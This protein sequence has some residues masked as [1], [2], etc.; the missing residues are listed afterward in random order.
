M[1]VETFGGAVSYLKDK[2]G[3]FDIASKREDILK[4]I[5][6]HPDDKTTEIAWLTF[7]KGTR[8]TT[9]KT[10]DKTKTRGL[11]KATDLETGAEYQAESTKKLGELIGFSGA[12]ISHAR[13]ENRLI[14][15][16][17]KITCDKVEVKIDTGVR[18][19]IWMAEDTETNEVLE[20]KSARELGDLLGVTD[21]NVIYARKSGKLVAKRYKITKKKKRNEKTHDA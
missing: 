13:A 16:R 15:K 18:P 14:K 6:G 21:A 9:R 17:Y 19:Y 10:N 5:N 20:T 2:F 11:W 7:L 3:T 1:L 12:T 8:Q 4:R